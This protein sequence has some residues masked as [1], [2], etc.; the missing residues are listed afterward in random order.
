LLK[1][2][3]V[4]LAATRRQWPHQKWKLAIKAEH[5]AIVDNGTYH[6]VPLPPWHKPIRTYLRSRTRLMGL[7]I[8]TRP[9]GLL[10]DSARAGELTMMILLHK[11]NLCTLLALG[12]IHGL[13]IHQMDI[14]T[15]FFNAELEEEI[16]IMQPEGFIDPEHPD[17]VCCL[18]KSLCGLKHT[19]H[20]WYKL[21]DTHLCD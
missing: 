21:I 20:E 6:F 18:D 5:R 13:E 4:S 2:A 7:W 1:V 17:H 11:D 3:E 19:A 14:D 10:E 9:V 12:F 16:Y 8:T 15:A